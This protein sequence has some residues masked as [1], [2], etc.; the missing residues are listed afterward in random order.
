VELSTPSAASIRRPPVNSPSALAV[1]VLALL[2]TGVLALLV[3][4]HQ[5]EVVFAIGHQGDELLLWGCI[6]LVINF[7]FTFETD[8]FQFTLDLPVLLAVAA[9]Y[10][11]AVG[12]LVAAVA[13]IDSR[14]VERRVTLSRA[15]FNRAQI[16]ISVYVA[17]LAFHQ[18][19]AVTGPWPRSL[20]GIVAAFSVFFLVNGAFVTVGSALWRRISWRRAAAS[21]KVGRP[22]EFLLT[23]L[24]Y[25]ILALVLARLAQ[26]VGGWAVA[27]FLIPVLVAHFA[28][29]R[30]EKLRFLADRLQHRERLLELLSER[31]VDERRD[32]RLRIASDLH[33]DVLQNV[34]KIWIQARFVRE[35]ESAATLA[36][37]AQQLVSDAE[38]TLTSLRNVISDLRR[39][40]LGRG[41]LAA[42][43]EQL[44]RDLKLD[45]GRKISFESLLG[46]VSGIPSE[47]QLVAYQVGKEALINALKHSDS[48][49]IRISA[50]M[51]GNRL[52]VEVVDS[53]KGF[54]P[55]TVDA[56]EHFGLGLM[57][58]R[59]RLVGGDLN[60]ESTRGRGTQVVASLPLG[61]SE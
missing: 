61:G 22:M 10:H 40:P 16:G 11:P 32:E 17:S 26:D 58:E 51:K 29:V 12:G 25:G 48:A 52:V 9:L 54:D 57:R 28:L 3:I 50:T 45:W 4:P 60:V 21:L 8:S 5:D 1:R 53:G 55:E 49:F 2:A 41:G 19:A 14:E 15:L 34:T 37:D 38:I 18:V 33:D 44:V 7:F 20:F 24:G 42:T 27:L 43:L 36:T 30:A 6:I 13:E 35:A 46:D 59:I 56:S 39:S 31:I 47:V 23:Y